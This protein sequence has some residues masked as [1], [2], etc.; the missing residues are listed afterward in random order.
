MS[1]NDTSNKATSLSDNDDDDNSSDCRII[2]P[3]ESADGLQRD[4]DMDHAA[5][6]HRSDNTEHSRPI[7]RKNPVERYGVAEA[8]ANDDERFQSLNQ[9]DQERTEATPQ[10]LMATTVSNPNQIDHEEMDR[11]ETI[12]QTL[13]ATTVPNAKKDDNIVSALDVMSPGERI[14]FQR[15]LEMAA[16]IRVLKSLVVDNPLNG[17]T[18]QPIRRV[19]DAKLLEIGLPLGE[20]ENLGKFEYDLLKEEFRA[21]VVSQHIF[22][23]CFPNLLLKVFDWC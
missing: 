12:P 16:D 22:Y 15:L 6:R 11:T 13:I 17:D 23:Y 19:D 18:S 7:R 9:S 14:I 21:S 2:F 8:K 20:K 4:D 10:L 3:N 1:A 5:K